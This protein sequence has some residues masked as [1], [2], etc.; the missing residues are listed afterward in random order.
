MERREKWATYYAGKIIMFEI[1][2]VRGDCRGIKRGFRWKLLVIILGRGDLQDCL[3]DLW[4]DIL[5]VDT[6]HFILTHL[7]FYTSLI[8]LQNLYNFAQGIVPP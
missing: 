5:F 2:S 1:C 3:F 4:L 8:P 7:I 6:H